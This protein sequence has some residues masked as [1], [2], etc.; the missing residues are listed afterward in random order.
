MEL[1]KDFVA[2]LDLVATGTFGNE[3]KVIVL[4]KITEW[5]ARLNSNPQV[6]K[7]NID[8]CRNA[9]IMPVKYQAERQ[10]HGIDDHVKRTETDRDQFINSAHE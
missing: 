8:K 10:Q 6:E 5:F 3:A 4:N 1:N 9:D 7:K 2:V